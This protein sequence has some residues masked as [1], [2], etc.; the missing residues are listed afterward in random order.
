MIC[1][2]CKEE[3]DPTQFEKYRS[4]CKKCKGNQSSEWRRNNRE[5]VSVVR[6][7][8]RL[9]NLDEHIKKDKEKREKNTEAYLNRIK[10]YR[11]K[12]PE[13]CREAT[14]KWQ[15]NNPEKAIEW[16]RNNKDKCLE[17]TYR[18]REKHPEKAIVSQRKAIQIQRVKFPEKNKARKLVFTALREGFMMRPDKCSDC[19]KECKPDAHHPD[20]SKP[21]EVIWLCRECHNKEHGK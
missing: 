14:R 10:R 21:L 11:E 19:N 15:K 12:Y 6:R 9:E 3:K 13:R 20:Y 16:R 1:T 5:R 18:W 8:N 2:E 4:K 17:Y 7:K